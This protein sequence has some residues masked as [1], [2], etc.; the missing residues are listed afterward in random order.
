VEEVL[1]ELTRPA[2]TY[3]SGYFRPLPT[4]PEQFNTFYFFDEEYAEFIS[5]VI[6]PQCPVIANRVFFAD[7]GI[8]LSTK[9]L[10]SRVRTKHSRSTMVPG[11]AL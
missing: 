3:E 10:T 1:A 7:Q 11:H 2:V 9:A 5:A 8:L 4:V 6:E